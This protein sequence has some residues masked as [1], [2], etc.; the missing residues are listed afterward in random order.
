MIIGDIANVGM[1][2][3]PYLFPIIDFLIWLLAGNY[4]AL[5]GVFGNILSILL[6][7][8]LRKIFGSLFPNADWI[9]APDSEDRGKCR[10]KEV[11]WTTNQG[12]IIEMPSLHAQ[13]VAYYSTFWL[14]VLAYNISGNLSGIRSIASIIL[15]EIFGFV[16]CYTRYM[17]EYSSLA[18]IIT[19]YIVGCFW[20]AGYYFLLK[21]L[22]SVTTNNTVSF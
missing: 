17:M 6:N 16:L 19:G 1:E 7:L 3:S 10:V 13:Q 5:A 15:L 2:F 4:H 12:R 11:S 14:I 18:Q 8:A 20:G 9:Y 22:V 21:Y